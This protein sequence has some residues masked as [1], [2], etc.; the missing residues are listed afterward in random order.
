MTVYSEPLKYSA[1]KV[2]VLPKI[3]YYFSVWSTHT[4]SHTTQIESLQR[5]AERWV[6]MTMVK[7]QA[8]QKCYR[9]TR[10]KTHI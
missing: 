6:N 10:Y 3:E 1:Y 2:L 5:R 9:Q 7:N 8:S 4:N